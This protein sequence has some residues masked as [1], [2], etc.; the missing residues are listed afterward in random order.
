M[1][2]PSTQKFRVAA[3]SYNAQVP[4]NRSILT[5]QERSGYRTRSMRY[6]LV[7]LTPLQ[8]SVGMRSR[9]MSLSSD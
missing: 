1:M 7:I 3:Y 8:R 4:W 6:A 2:L 9:G 5:E